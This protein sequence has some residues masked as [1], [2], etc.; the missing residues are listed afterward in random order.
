MPG[1]P[2]PIHV[3]IVAIPDSMT[4]PVVGI[5]ET[6]LI[7]GLIGAAGPSFQTEIVGRERG[8]LSTATGLP[9]IVQRSFDEVE[10]TDVVITT[11]MAMDENNQWYTGRHPE[12]VD[13]MRAMN[14]QGSMLCSGC[15]GV[16]LLAETGLLDGLEATIHWAYAP[17][18]RRNFPRVRVNLRKVLVTGGERQEFVMTGAS[19]SWQDL[20]LYLIARFAGQETAR[21]VGRF[22]L[23]QWHQESQAPYVSFAPPTDHGDAVVGELQQWLARHYSVASPVE[24]MQRRAQLSETTFKRRF[25]KATGCSPLQYVQFLRVEKAK[26]LLEGSELP[27][28]DVTW[29]VGYEDAAFFRRLFKRVTGMT[30]GNYRRKFRVPEF[31]Q[32]HG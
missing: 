1:V 20:A 19:G 15:T 25:K 28:D 17:T 22:L 29:Q 26:R 18:F 10:R 12:A 31:A 30:P 27:V 13:W 14:R 23:M 8:N 16:L 21:D 5:Y 3:S 9:V 7:H 11:S 24:E 2:Q 6:L 32:Q 4:A